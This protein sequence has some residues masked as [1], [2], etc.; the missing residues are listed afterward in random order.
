MEFKSI[1]QL[2]ITDCCNKLSITRERLKQIV[3]DTNNNIS[4]FHGRLFCEG[5]LAEEKEE[6]AQRLFLLISE[7]RKLFLRSKTAQQHEEYLSKMKDGLWRDEASKRITSFKIEQIEKDFYSKNKNTVEGLERYLRKYPHGTFSQNARKEIA[8]R[9]RSKTTKSILI[10]AALVAL[11][12]IICFMNFHSSSYISSDSDVTFGKKGGTASCE[13]STDAIS[14]N[15]QAY[16]TENW[17]KATL[18]NGALNIKASPN[19]GDTRYATIHLYAYTT[20]FGLNLWKKEFEIN[21]SENSGLSTFLTVSDSSFSFDKYGSGEVYST[22]ETDGMNLKI[23][24]DVNW[25]TFTKDVSERGDNFLAK[26]VIST[27]T[28][29]TGE[30]TGTITVKSDKYEQKIYVRQNS[31]LATYFDLSTNSLVM[32]EEGTEEGYYYSV[33]VETDGTTWSVS[34][35]PDWLTAEAKIPQGKLHVTLP[36]NT[37]KIKTGTITLVSNNGDSIYISVK[38]WGDPTDFR[39]SSN[40]VKYGISSGY[41][42]I[43]IT[44]NSNKS[45]SVSEDE[46]WISS[47]VISNSKIKIYCSQNNSSSRSGNV[48]V[49]CGNEELNISI[50]QDGWSDCTNCKGKGYTPCPGGAWDSTTG[51]IVHSRPKL[52]SNFNPYTGWSHKWTTDNC[53][54]CGGNGKIKCRTCNGKGKIYD[55][56]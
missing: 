44:N 41:T 32:S 49:T 29:E 27:K 2:S 45:I 46:S 36:E 38:Q 11:V 33:N 50:E 18:E 8:E 17:I 9:R 20:L 6:I 5:S 7:D 4:L 47:S 16:V 10:S 52:I 48:C 35:A 23:T 24:S 14:E 40:K 37:G 51:T 1:E 53:P 54:T 42:Y 26:L 13:I 55:S 22:V 43:N 12:L 31:G 3:I 21:V 39:A 25:I 15:I 30:R 19:H 56:Y 34:S 28:N